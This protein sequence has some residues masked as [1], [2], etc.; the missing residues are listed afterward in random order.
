[1]PRHVWSLIYFLRLEHSQAL[2]NYIAIFSITKTQN[3]PYNSGA[4]TIFFDSTAT[5]HNYFWLCTVAERLKNIFFILRSH[6]FSYFLFFLLHF[7]LRSHYFSS[8]CVA[9]ISM[10]FILRSHYFSSLC[11]FV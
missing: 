3:V 4:K 10:H 11:V 7:I 6:N 9:M 5:V 1:M 2:N 8:L